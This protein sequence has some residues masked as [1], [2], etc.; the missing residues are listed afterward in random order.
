MSEIQGIARL[1]IHTGKLEE[2]KRCAAQCL[3]S[4]RTKDTGTL[5]YDMY[6]NSDQTECLAYERYRDSK[7]L[8][9][10]LENLGDLMQAMLETC[11]ITGE[12]LGN[13]SAELRKGLEGSGVKIYAPYH[14]ID[15]A[16]PIKQQELRRV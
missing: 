4:V 7:A 6:I 15:G 8:L 12:I 3:E 14:S 5:Q 11:S 1:A 9:E 10:H 2:F 13:P 16:G